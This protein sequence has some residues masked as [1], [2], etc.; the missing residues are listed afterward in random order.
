[1][2][3]KNGWR[4]NWEQGRDFYGWTRHHRTVKLL[5]DHPPEWAEITYPYGD[6]RWTLRV[7]WGE[8]P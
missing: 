1:M 3:E 5:L 2:P 4:Y 6:N 7:E 8:M